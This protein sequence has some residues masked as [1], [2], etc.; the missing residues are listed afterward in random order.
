MT[1]KSDQPVPTAEEEKPMRKCSV[2]SCG[3]LFST[4][5]L[6]KTAICPACFSASFKKKPIR[7]PAVD[8]QGFRVVRRR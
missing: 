1:D 7:A 3:T 5:F 8:G 4:G 2:E 6:G